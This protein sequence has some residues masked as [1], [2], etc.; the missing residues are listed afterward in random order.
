MEAP[1]CTPIPAFVTP[2]LSN[3]KGFIR[4]LQCGVR[5][6][7]PVHNRKLKRGLWVA[8]STSTTSTVSKLLQQIAEVAGAERG[9]FGQT[10]EER[11]R[12]ETLIQATEAENP[13]KEPTANDAVAADGKWRLI[14]TT[15]VILGR[16]RVRLALSTPKKSGLVKL[17]QLWQIVD[18]KSK[19]TQNVVEFSVLGTT[20][21][22]TLSATYEPVSKDR[23]EVTLEDTCLQPSALSKI[24]G[25]NEKLLVQIFN[26]D[27]YLD[28]TYIDESLRIGRNNKGQL[29]VLEKVNEDLSD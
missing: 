17:G 18:S 7:Q 20:G 25:E 14:Y 11:Q 9:I 15:L 12:L 10:D 19:Q 27:G 4:S 21:T 29:F 16:R 23:V 1:V 24:L 28:I 3:S 2:V 13:T 22:F 26:P 5:G 6:L 8:C